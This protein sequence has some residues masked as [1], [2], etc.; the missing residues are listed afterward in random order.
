MSLHIIGC[1]LYC[2]VTCIYLFST[3][4]PYSNEHSVVPEVWS[5]VK[6]SVPENVSEAEDVDGGVSIT[7]KVDLTN[8]PPSYKRRQDED[9][10]EEIESTERDQNTAVKKVRI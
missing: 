4:E 9:E 8:G 5:Y 3:V 6:S 10:E 1:N 2:I 7:K